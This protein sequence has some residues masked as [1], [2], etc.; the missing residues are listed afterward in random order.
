VELELYVTLTEDGERMGGETCM[1]GN[2][3]DPELEP[4]TEE[5]LQK[6]TKRRVILHKTRPYHL[7]RARDRVK[8]FRLF[9][10]LMFYLHSGKAEIRSSTAGA[11]G[12]ALVDA[13]G[14]IFGIIIQGVDLI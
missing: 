6:R 10:Y 5:E 11:S 12:G 4:I 3:T 14:H 2:L 1:N 7:R 8:F 13:N 9:A